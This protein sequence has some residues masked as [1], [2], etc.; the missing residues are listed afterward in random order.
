MFD[1]RMQSF[2]HYQTGLET[3]VKKEK[4]IT[5]AVLNGLLQ[6]AFSL[7]SYHLHHERY[8]GI[9]MALTPPFFG[10]NWYS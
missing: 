10:S 9:G 5:G 4:L 8:V 3:R 7:L 6:S 2:F 1:F